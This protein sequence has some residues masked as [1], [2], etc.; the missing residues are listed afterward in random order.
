MKWK[1]PAKLLLWL[2]IQRTIMALGE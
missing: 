1:Y 2:Q